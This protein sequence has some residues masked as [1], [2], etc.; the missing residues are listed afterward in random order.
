MLYPLSFQVQSEEEQY[1]DVEQESLE[2]NQ[3][4]SFIDESM[5]DQPIF[6]GPMT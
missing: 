4:E 5:E 6:H 1:D 3:S 2:E